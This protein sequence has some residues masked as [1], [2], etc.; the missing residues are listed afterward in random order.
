MKKCD[1]LKDYNWPDFTTPKESDTG[2]IQAINNTR[3]NKINCFW[4][5]SPIEKI[6][7]ILSENG[8]TKVQPCDI[9]LMDVNVICAWGE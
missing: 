1:E 9:T 8:V 7:C 6:G 4:L 3:Q 2:F 5:G